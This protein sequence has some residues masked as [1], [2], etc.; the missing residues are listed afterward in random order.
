MT[1]QCVC[2]S[3]PEASISHSGC[4][5]CLDLRSE[6]LRG[7]RNSDTAWTKASYELRRLAACNNE[8]C[9]GRADIHVIAGRRAIIC[10]QSRHRSRRRSYSLK[11]AQTRYP[12]RDPS[13]FAK[14]VPLD[15]SRNDS[16]THH[17]VP[18]IQS[19]QHRTKLN[20][21]SEYKRSISRS[22]THSICR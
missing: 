3:M 1:S 21:V 15:I 7:T 20:I 11:P 19:E 5:H 2:W 4:L 9:I 10:A 14:K 16:G 17:V 6:T 18:K 12:E 22:T 8:Y 13:N